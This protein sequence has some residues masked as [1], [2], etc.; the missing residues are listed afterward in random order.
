VIDVESRARRA[1]EAAR[2]EASARAGHLEVPGAAGDQVGRR[3]ARPLVGVLTGAVV[4]LLVVLLV[5]QLAPQ[6]APIIEPAVPDIADQVVEPVAVDGTLPVPPVGEAIAAY[7]EDGTPVFVS[8]PEDGEVYVLEAFDGHGP[9]GVQ[10]MVHWCPSAQQFAEARHGTRFNAYGDY[11]GGPAPRPLLDVPSEAV[12]DA[13]VRVT[14]P[15]APPRERT[16][17]RAEV[18]LAGPHCLQGEGETELMDGAVGHA[19]PTEVPQLDGSALPQGRWVWAEVRLGGPEGDARVCELDGRCPADAPRIAPG[20]GTQ[21]TPDPDELALVLARGSG[22]S[23]DLALGPDPTW[24]QLPAVGSSPAALPIPEPGEAELA[25]LHD[26]TPVIVT[27]EAGEVR[28]VDAV[29]ATGSDLVAWCPE[30][31]FLADG[32]GS[33]WTLGGAAVTPDLAG[34]PTYPY[35]VVAD[36][37][38]QALRVRG[39]ATL[40]ARSAAATPRGDGSERCR[41][42]ALEGHRPPDGSGVTRLS[43]YVGDPDGERHWWWVEARIAEVDGGLV[44]CVYLGPDA[45]GEPVPTDDTDADCYADLP[46]GGACADRDP[47]IVTAGLSPTDE[48]VLLLV[49]LAAEGATVEVRRPAGS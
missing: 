41:G 16:D 47:T 32:A 30:A 46:T 36:G 20:W 5:G 23:A 13:R 45:C 26:R 18:P 31:G 27:H 17:V 49:R 11:A 22:A 14:G 43:P 38:S 34:L 2:T 35:D 1:G 7:L 4:L 25:Y 6:P 42:A 44:L 8:H 24:S 40:D 12:D 29:T 3:V 37:D 10:E 15:P 28:I 48:P 33:V 9:G 21:V 39:P 19:R